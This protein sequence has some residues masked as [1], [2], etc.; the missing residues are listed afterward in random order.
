MKRTALNLIQGTDLW[1]AERA[2]S[3]GTASEAP[4]MF[5]KSKYQT[6]TELLNQRKTGIAKSVDS[7]TQAIFNKGHDAE[8]KARS[9]A[10][11]II[12]EELSPVTYMIEI[13]G[14]NLM[15]SLDG[16]TFDDTII[17]EH[18]LWNEKL[19]AQIASGQLEEHY[20]IQLDQEL[21][22]SGATKC[23]FMTS[24]GTE[25]KCAYM[26]YE[27]HVIL[28]NKII[29]G[30][31]QFKSD[32]ATHV[33]TEVKQVPKAQVIMALPTLAIAIKG[34]VTQSNL[35]EFKDA[36]TAFISNIKTE[37]V[38]DQDFADAESMTKFLD[39]AEKNIESAKN[40][41]I[42]QTSS[43][44]ELMRTLDFIKNQ[45]RDKRLSLKKL[46]ESEKEVRK[47][48]V[49]NEAR[50][51]FTKHK[52]SHLPAQLFFTMPDF[53]VATKNKKTIASMKEAVT[54]ML[55]NAKIELDA[56]ARDINRKTVWFKEISTGFESVFPDFETI[57]Y[58]AEDDFKLLVQ[59]RIDAAKK[60]EEDRIAKVKETQEKVA[61]ELLNT[62]FAA[63]KTTVDE[64]SNISLEMVDIRENA[65]VANIK[66][67]PSPESIVMALASA[68][69]VGTEV[70]LEWLLNSDFNN[71]D[72][73]K[74]A[75]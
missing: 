49:I 3:D 12:G 63:I 27:S 61:S 6:R 39:D 23:L 69:K 72:F 37:L 15:A 67:K 24:D 26:W 2:S 47:M 29:A 54:Q 4:A 65:P 57:K 66:V 46:V 17:W 51:E 9:I 44:D 25:D 71:V 40:A 59:M 64:Q 75:A 19:A 53:S 14:L 43:I 18:K 28:A 10:E 41:A 70:A 58:K 32:L 34:E 30:W 16:I 21:L 42:A 50:A 45:L 60:A 33:V 31:K 8:S 56:L 22:A 55:T 11:K 13:E 35:V 74:Q 38:S 5:G 62:G 48:A 73:D 7:A 1:L 20:T 68:Y 52:D 36:A